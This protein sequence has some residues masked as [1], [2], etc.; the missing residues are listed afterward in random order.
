[1]KKPSGPVLNRNK[2]L[3]TLVAN[4]EKIDSYSVRKIGLFGSYLSG[5]Q[6]KGSDLDFLVVFDKPTFRNYMGLKFF[7]EDLFHRKVDLVIEEDL[8]PE[9]KY[10][11]EEAVYV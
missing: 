9:L 3:K 1:M 10:V 6:K 5:R 4:R 11:R 2:I 7:L 8:K